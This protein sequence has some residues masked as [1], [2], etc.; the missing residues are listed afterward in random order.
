MLHKVKALMGY[1]IRAS[2]GEIGHVED[3]LLDE[4]GREVRF[5]QVDTSNWIGGKRVIIAASAIEGI[6][7]SRGEIR[8]GMTRAAVTGA[9]SVESADID[10]QETRPAVWI[11]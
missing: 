10:P 2:D 1:H 6:D 9:P 7:S 4:R 5:L 3:V 11:M 8:L